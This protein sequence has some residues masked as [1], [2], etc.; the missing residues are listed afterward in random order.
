VQR[1][2]QVSDF[3]DFQMHTI[4]SDGRW[5]P[6]ELLDYLATHG[7]RV[8]AITDHDTIEHVAELQTL[9]AERGV[10][11]I[12]ATELSMEWQGKMADVLCYGFDLADESL[13]RL[14]QARVEKQRQNTV[15]V[16][17]ALRR[18]GYTFP[19]QEEVLAASGGEPQRPSDNARL[20]RQHGYAPDWPSAMRIITEAGFRE[21]RTD[22]AEGVATIHR[23]GGVALIAHPGRR[24]INFTLYD[25]PL[26][27]AVSQDVPLDGIEVYH[28]THTPE[29][30]AEYRA[31]ATARGW[32]QSAGSDSHG[33][34]HRY[35]IAYTADKVTALL[36]R[37]G[38]EV[39]DPA[40]QRH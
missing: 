14:I 23:A 22:L 6:E 26:L 7:F 16:Y 28:P 2:I 13:H 36:Q 5:Q 40:V 38:F 3:V 19:R 18:R 1:T 37:L 17:Q 10:T 34:H 29:Q 25:L 4:Y 31:Y 12:T 24:E 9:G 33:P 11:V 30:T 20:L 15:A 27:D 35:P 39:V 32:L 8:V 21:I